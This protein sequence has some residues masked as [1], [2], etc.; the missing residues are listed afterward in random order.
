MA[1]GIVTGLIEAATSCREDAARRYDEDPAG[2]S[3]LEAKAEDFE[4]G[5]ENELREALEAALGYRPCA[6]LLFSTR[7]RAPNGRRGMM[8]VCLEESGVVHDH[9]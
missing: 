1:I 7:S 4:A 8:S 2:A 6:Q 5:A 9:G 3:A